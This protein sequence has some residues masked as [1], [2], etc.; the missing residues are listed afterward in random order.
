MSSASVG[1]RTGKLWFRA[2][3]PGGFSHVVFVSQ[4]GQLLSPAI[5][6]DC[7][8]AKPIVIKYDPADNSDHKV[9]GMHD[10]QP[11]CSSS[12]CETTDGQ[13]CDCD[14]Y[15]T[16]DCDCADDDDDDDSAATGAGVGAGA[17]AG[18]CR[19]PSGNAAMEDYDK[20]TIRDELM[21]MKGGVKLLREQNND[22]LCKLDNSVIVL[23]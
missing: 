3:T 20:E 4:D 8:K 14:C 9:Y 5:I 21:V 15:C 1:V 19:T 2:R 22:L 17:G 6:L 11:S 12:S 7:D 10:R 13:S 16:D 23:R 18:R